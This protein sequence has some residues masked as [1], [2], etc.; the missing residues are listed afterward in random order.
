MQR[1]EAILLSVL[2]AVASTSLLAHAQEMSAADTKYWI[3]NF[4]EKHKF[5]QDS[6]V[7]LKSSVSTQGD[8]RWL[9]LSE[10]LR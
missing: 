5:C 3:L 9:G 7:R 8:E 6:V 4:V 10:Q 2:L 1:L